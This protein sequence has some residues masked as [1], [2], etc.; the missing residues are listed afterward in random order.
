MQALEERANAAAV[1]ST[2]FGQ[3]AAEAVPKSL[4]C[5][6]MRLTM[7][8]AMEPTLH[9]KVHLIRRS[10]R[11]T[12][13]TLYHFCIFSDNVLATSVV[14]NSTVCSAKDP[15]ELVFHIVTDHMNYG[16]MQTWFL[17]NNFRYFII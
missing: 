14:V 16:A 8:W 2:V 4:H 12:D 1:Q 17:I 11:L 13:N 6:G 3:L 10:R 7:E 9:R 15:H 5:L